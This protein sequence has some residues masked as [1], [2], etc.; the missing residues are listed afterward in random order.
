M[1]PLE[2]SD[3]LTL[4]R[5]YRAR[6]RKEWVMSVDAALLKLV[7]CPATRKKLI[8]AS[9]DLVSSL[10]LAI[11]AGTLTNVGGEVVTQAFCQAL[12][13]ADRSIAYPVRQGIPHL[14]I[15]EGVK[16]GSDGAL[17]VAKL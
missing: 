13:T 10:N 2:S 5:E 12:I 17:D 4:N 8:V 16:V 15:N 11:E 14:L 6:G 7:L 3:D 9:E 1:R